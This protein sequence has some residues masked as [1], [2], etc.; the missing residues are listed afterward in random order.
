[1]NVNSEKTR[2][3]EGGMGDIKCIPFLDNEQDC[4]KLND[5]KFTEMSLKVK[6][7]TSHSEYS[8]V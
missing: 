5:Y 8:R 3:M 2:G 4:S 6:V 1:M 7:V